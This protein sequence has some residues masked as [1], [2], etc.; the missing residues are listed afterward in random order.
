M[1]ASSA[2]IIR[3]LTAE[4][5]PEMERRYCI[6]NGVLRINVKP[7]DRTLWQDTLR[8]IDEPGNV[9]LAC[10]SSSCAL[11]STQLT[12]VV[13][14]AIRDTSIDQADAIVS[15]LE[16]LGVEPPLAKAVPEHCPGLAG[17]VT[18]AFYLERHGWLTA[19]P[20]LPS[21]PVA[22]ASQ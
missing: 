15:L 17:E 21:K 13:G 9:L 3:S 19:S 11:E 10:E 18:W 1:T 7:D 22:N 14:A 5:A 20:I 8:L 6:G 4:L 12:W 2:T 16:T